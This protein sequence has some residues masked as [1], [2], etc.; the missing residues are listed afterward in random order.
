MCVREIA[1]RTRSLQEPYVA[2]DPD[3]PSRIALGVNAGR[4]TTA[5][6]TD[7]HPGLDRVALDVFVSD[8]GG[9]SF[10]HR[11]LP[12]VPE[13]D[14]GPVDSSVAGD[15]ALAW[16]GNGSLYV[17]G[18][19][20]HKANPS[21]VGGYDV[22]AART[23]DLGETWSRPVPLT[24]DDDNDRQWLSI[25]PDG[26]VYVPWHSAPGPELAWKPQG[27]SWQG[28][29][30][31]SELEGCGRPS[32]V[33]FPNGTPV[34]ACSVVGGEG[35]VVVSSDPPVQRVEVHR[36]DPDEGTFALRS[37]LNASTVA[38]QL[39]TLPNE[40]LVLAGSSGSTVEAW[41]SHDAGRSWT[42]AVDLSE[43]LSSSGDWASADLKWTATDPWGGLHVLVEADV[44]PDAQAPTCPSAGPPEIVH[45][46][47]SPTLDE[48]LAERAL[49]PPDTSLE[50]HR[51]AS[52]APGYGDHFF[53]IDFGPERGYLV[54]TEDK[55]LEMTTVEPVW[56]GTSAP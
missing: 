51:P 40:T 15:P 21:P 5:P 14:A 9:A 46:A 52:A 42:D 36:F 28:P 19:V 39:T 22:F 10:Q 8:D 4:T 54:W 13:D 18:I 16:A 35:R 56:N 34:F 1:D 2:V 38:R 41:L 33:A 48:V 37:E 20:N 27:S 43:G 25:G 53:G 6:R 50:E 29:A 47:F 12:Y 44:C 24:T 23:D 3:E 49:D 45:A 31:A 11:P 55:A 26:T 32:S 17:S 7:P 30:Q